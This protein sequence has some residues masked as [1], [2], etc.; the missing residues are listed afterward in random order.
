LGADSEDT[1]P[2]TGQGEGCSDR[3]I[4]VGQ[5]VVP[6]ARTS[7]TVKVNSA[8]PYKHEDYHGFCTICG[9]VWPCARGTALSSSASPR[10]VGPVPRGFQL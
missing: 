5:E 3:P 1:P 10:F 2:A 6:M 9:S 8:F 4:D 7:E